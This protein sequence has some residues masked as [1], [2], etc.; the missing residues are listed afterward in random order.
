MVVT[1]IGRRKCKFGSFLPNSD[2][3]V[4]LVSGSVDFLN[5]HLAANIDL[6]IVDHYVSA[7]KLPTSTM[8]LVQIQDVWCREASTFQTLWGSTILL[9]IPDSPFKQKL[10][11]F[12]NY[13]NWHGKLV[14]FVPT[15]YLSEND[16]LLVHILS[17]NVF[18]SRSPSA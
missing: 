17:S 9:Q 6:E 12:L 18:L 11:Y 8:P 10:K 7:C 15:N 16:L 4:T 13:R 1:C 3:Y 2:A 14:N 5:K